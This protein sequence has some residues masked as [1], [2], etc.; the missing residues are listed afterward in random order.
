MQMWDNYYLRGGGTKKMLSYE[1]SKCFNHAKMC[2]VGAVWTCPDEQ[3]RSPPSPLSRSHLKLSFG[4]AEPGPIS[5]D[6]AGWEWFLSGIHNKKWFLFSGRC[7]SIILT[8]CPSL[9]SWAGLIPREW[10]HFPDGNSEHWLEGERMGGWWGFSSVL[11]P[12][13]NPR[14]LKGILKTHSVFIPCFSS[15]IWA[16]LWCLCHSCLVSVFGHALLKCC[17]PC[18]VLNGFTNPHFHPIFSNIWKGVGWK[19]SLLSPPYHYFFLALVWP[20]RLFFR[21]RNWDSSYFKLFVREEVIF[22]NQR[23]HTRILSQ[24]DCSLHLWLYWFRGF[25]SL[26]F[27]WIEDKGWECVVQR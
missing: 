3:W 13:R 20:L 11:M 22:R 6:L 23:E 18:T 25:C 16:P 24:W 21:W 14:Q 19:I 7:F 17:V 5:T 27:Y 8:A 26:F 4:G 9:Y 12:C 10:S 1:V 15:W 2:S